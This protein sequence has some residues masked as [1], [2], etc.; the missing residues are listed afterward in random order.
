MEL[1]NKKYVKMNKSDIFLQLV[2]AGATEKEQDVK[3]VN[4]F[5][6]LLNVVMDYERTGKHRNYL[7]E[8]Y[9]SIDDID[10]TDTEVTRETIVNALVYASITNDYS[11]VEKIKPYLY[12]KRYVVSI[13]NDILD[14]IL[15]HGINIDEL[16]DGENEKLIFNSNTNSLESGFIFEDSIKLERRKK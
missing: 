2:R 5:Q 14:Y 7:E 10:I 9:L 6:N 3:K 8:F 13:G 12:K 1:V 15:E 4:F 16:I 11:M